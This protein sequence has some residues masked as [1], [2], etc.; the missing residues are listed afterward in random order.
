VH[1]LGEGGIGGDG[2]FIFSERALR[3]ALGEEV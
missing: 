1:R 2:V 3:I